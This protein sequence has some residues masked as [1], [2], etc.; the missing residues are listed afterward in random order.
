MKRNDLERILQG[1]IAH[2][3]EVDMYEPT[4][5]VTEL[6]VLPIYVKNMLLN[7]LSGKTTAQELTKWALFLIY[8]TGEYV[9]INWENEKS[10]AFYEDMF[11]VVQRLSSPEIDGEVT[12]ESVR[13]YLTELAK[14]FKGN[15]EQY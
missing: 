7:Y 10:T 11:Y 14:Y 2:I 3:D 13:Q 1:D 15:D 12:T 5:H 6:P 4:D 9:C 8:R